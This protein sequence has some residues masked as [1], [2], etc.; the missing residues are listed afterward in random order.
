M[1]T[2]LISIIVPCYKQA[3]FL[4]ESLQSVLEQTYGHWECIIVN[5]GSPDNTG[6][7]ATEWCRKDARFK[8]L[9][10][11]NGGLSSARNV[12]IEASKGTFILPLDADDLLH[13]NYLKY[14]VPVLKGDQKLAIVTPYS[15]FFE[16]NVGNVVNELKPKGDSYPYLLYVNQLVATF[17]IS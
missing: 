4:K 14:L 8:Y 11:E 13:K 6:K 2:P 5:D 9:Y 1:T 16:G 3:H 10:K 12:G 7:V 17:S 15:I